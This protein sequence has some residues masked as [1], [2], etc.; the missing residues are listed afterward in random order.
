M[1]LHN[2]FPVYEKPIIINDMKALL[3]TLKSSLRDIINILEELNDKL[4][5]ILKLPSKQTILILSMST[6]LADI[7]FC[8]AKQHEYRH[9]MWN[10]EDELKL[11]ESDDD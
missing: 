9:L 2:K 11:S 10:I 5:I 8:L 3:L 1:E 6:V 4:K 7:S